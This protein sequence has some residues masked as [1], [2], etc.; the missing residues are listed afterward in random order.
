[1]CPASKG[2][3]A[4][5]NLALDKHPLKLDGFTF[6]A[7][8]VRAVG[9]PTKQQWQAALAFA[10]AAKEGS[11]WWVADLLKYARER[12]DWQE[13][14]D[15]I[16]SVTGL[17]PQTLRNLESLGN[18]I[19]EPE[20]RL[21][22]SVKH[23]DMV[24]KLPQ[25]E[26]RKMLIK[27]A[28][29]GWNS[30]ELKSNVRSTQRM[31]VLEG[32]AKLEG[33]FRVIL[34]PVPWSD[35]SPKELMALPVMAHAEPNSVLF[36]WVPTDLLLANPGPRDVLEAWGFEYASNLVWDRVRGDF[37]GWARIRHS[38]LI[39]ATRGAVTPE[40]PTP[41]PDSVQTYR[42]DSGTGDDKPEGFRKMIEQWFPK[43]R[44]VELFAS[45]KRA[46]WT[47]LGADSREWAKEAAS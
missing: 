44:K 29:E 34:A 4:G 26:Q 1:M 38:H 5:G 41:Q 28:D 13:A 47:S 8:S 46:G 21:A 40:Q 19:D 24:R 35:I 6:R 10:E 25:A 30:N 39:V 42:D 15:Q 17:A 27:A 31:K 16:L 7:R 2:L 36:M 43:G 37:G 22:P 9:A 20:R 3:T 33:M 32:Q 23:A 11:D 12:G 45:A 14:F 18:A